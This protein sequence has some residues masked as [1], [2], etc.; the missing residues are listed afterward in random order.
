MCLIGFIA[1]L[2]PPKPSAKLAIQG[3]VK[4]GVMVKVLTGD[5]ET[6]TKYV[7]DMVGIESNTILLGSDIINMSDEELKSKVMDV[8]IFA[9]LSPDQKARIIT[10]IKSNKHIVGFM[11]D[12]INDAP[13]LTLSDV[14]ISMGIMGS[15]ATIESSDVVI[16]DDNLKR[17]PDLIKISKRTKKIVLENIIFAG[18]TKLTFLILGA[19]GI[20]GMLLAVF[21]DVGVTLLAILNSLRVLTYKIKN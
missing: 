16:A 1:L 6:V 17:I 21:A 10:A 2:D 4:K 8:N 19:L 11:G 20:T 18:V 7:C 14:G 9:K 15:Q 13:A 3:L 5:N 12:G